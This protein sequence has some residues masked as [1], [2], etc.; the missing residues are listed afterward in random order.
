VMIGRSESWNTIDREL[1]QY[2]RDP[3]LWQQPR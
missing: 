3:V 2:G 1:E